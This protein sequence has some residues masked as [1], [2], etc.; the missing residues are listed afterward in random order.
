MTTTGS[1]ASIVYKPA[2]VNFQPENHFSRVQ[3]DRIRLVE[4]FGIEG[5]TKGGDENRQLNIM[6]LETLKELKKEGFQTDAGEMGEQIIIEGIIIDHLQAG[7][8]LQIG[9]SAIVEIIKARTGCNRFHRIQGLHP[10]KAAGRMGMMAKVVKSGVIQINS[11]V[12]ILGVQEL[13]V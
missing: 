10:S 11:D 8:Q 3:V 6:S 1:I 7:D 9:S 5:D 13:D 12:Q 4:G 2:Q